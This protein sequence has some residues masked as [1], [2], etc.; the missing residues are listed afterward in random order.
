MELSRFVAET[1]RNIVEGIQEAQLHAAEHDASVNPYRGSEPQSIDFELELSTSEGSESSNAS[2]VVGG[3]SEGAT[4][5]S[6]ANSSTV[7][8][9]RFKVPIRLPNQ[10]VP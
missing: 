10:P 9:I 5:R 7:G 3:I 4:G 1:I 8:R 6:S 2:V